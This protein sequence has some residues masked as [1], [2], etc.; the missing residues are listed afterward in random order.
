VDR[1]V[2]QARAAIDA[3]FGGL[4]LDGLNLELTFAE[5]L[6]HL[7][8]LIEV[9][10]DRVKPG[11]LLA[12]RGFGLLPR[13][14]ELVDGVVFESF[15]VRWTEDGGYAA[16]PP[17]MLEYHAQIAEKLGEL[18]VDLYA[19]DYADTPG[20]AA[21]ARRRARQ[22]GLTSVISDKALSRV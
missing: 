17:D 1:V 19:L 4:F 2:G 9:V 16:L 13:L 8:S 3:G 7:L 20:L 22:F 10:R 21:F 6:P 12:N 18:W 11:Y 5:D 15:S 14:A